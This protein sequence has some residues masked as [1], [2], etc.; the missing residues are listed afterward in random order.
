M[1]E[2]EPMEMHDEESEMLEDLELHILEV[3]TEYVEPKGQYHLTIGIRNSNLD[4]S[5][6]YTHVQMRVTP[7]GK[8]IEFY[9][10]DTFTEKVFGNRFESRPF[11]LHSGESQIFVIPFEWTGKTK[12]RPSQLNFEVEVWGQPIDIEH[13]VAKVSPG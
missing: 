2:S 3:P 9:R 6:W 8:S 10:D 5:L 4:D 7:G 13:G 11:T 12:R 1:A